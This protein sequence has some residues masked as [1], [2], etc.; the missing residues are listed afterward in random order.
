MSYYTTFKGRRIKTETPPV[1]YK[2]CRVCR[3]PLDQ[4]PKGR[5]RETCSDT[6]RQGKFRHSQKWYEKTS[7]RQR[8]NEAEK[9]LRAMERASGTITP[10]EKTAENMW[11]G[12]RTRL[13]LRLG[14][15]QTIPQCA[16]CRRP[17]LEE[18]G[19]KEIYC[20]EACHK[21]GHK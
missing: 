9:A 3:K 18:F 21:E 19:V 6:C 4:K 13:L 11:M 17:Y 10:D 14:M 1:R 8:I 7:K 20:S 15:G 2:N 5:P 16:V 12:D